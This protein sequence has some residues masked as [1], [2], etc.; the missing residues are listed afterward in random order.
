MNKKRV[1]QPVMFAV[2]V[3]FVWEVSGNI[4]GYLLP[5]VMNKFELVL[6]G[7]Y[8]Y[9]F[10]SESLTWLII[11]AI[12]N[13]YI[14]KPNNNLSNERIIKYIWVFLPVVIQIGTDFCTLISGNIVVKVLSVK[15]FL[16]IFSCF[17]GSMSIA[18]LEETVWRKVIFRNAMEKWGNTK[19]GII[20]A[21][22]FSA[23]LFGLCHYI[24]ILAGQGFYDTSKQVLAAICFGTFLAA[25]YYK[26]G[27]FLFPVIIH[28]LCNFSNFFMNEMLGWDYN[29]LKWDGALQVIISLLYLLFGIYMAV[30]DLFFLDFLSSNRRRGGL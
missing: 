30:D 23:L 18:L 21:V 27:N 14:R 10:L 9:M 11:C 12:F 22:I 20:C 15:G 26:T 6:S 1:S 13:K 5:A 7:Q 17:L 19:K 25:I 4:I 16:L 2:I 3:Y 8:W 24:N 29:L 28:G